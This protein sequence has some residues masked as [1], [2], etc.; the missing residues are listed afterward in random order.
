MRVSNIGISTNAILGLQH[1]SREV[2]QAQ[3]RTQT[4]LRVELASDDPNAASSIMSSA[5]SLRALDQY[6]RNINS[7]TS[8]SNTEEEVLNQLSKLLERAK[9]LGIQEGNG[10]A[11]A[12][13][14]LVAK[15]EVDQLMAFAI[16]QANTRFEGEYLFGGDQSTTMPITSPLPP[17]TTTPPTGQRGV[18]I[19]EGL[20][21]NVNHNASQIFLNSS[22]LTSLDQLTTALA[23]NDQVGIMNSI[24]TI[25]TA[26]SSVQTLLGD[27]GAQSNQLETT[28]QNITALNTTLKTFKSNLQD[29][30]MEQAVTTLVSKQNAYQSALLATSKVLTLSLADYMR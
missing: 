12:Q 19:G 5:G 29:I 23:A 22:L 10:S 7:A 27:V 28:T 9:Q 18:Q 16:Q 21:V 24:N 11:S 30:D 20:V 13:T 14:R 26:L 4:G 2:E 1:A 8:R 6:Q 3:R 15:S 25:D 17:F